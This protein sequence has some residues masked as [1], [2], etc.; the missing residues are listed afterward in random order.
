M[1]GGHHLCSLEFPPSVTSQPQPEPGRLSDP[2]SPDELVF[3]WRFDGR[4][5]QRLAGSIASQLATFGNLYTT[6]KVAEADYI[7]LPEEVCYGDSNE[8][9]EALMAEAKEGVKV[10]VLQAHKDAKIE[11]ATRKM[12]SPPP[13]YVTRKPFGPRSFA[14][15]IQ[16]AVK[17]PSPCP[18]DGSNRISN[19]D[20]L[21]ASIDVIKEELQAQHVSQ[22]Q[23]RETQE[24]NHTLDL[25]FP[26][27]ESDQVLRSTPP[28]A[29]TISPLWEPKPARTFSAL[30]VEDNAL[31]MRILTRVLSQCGVPFAMAV[32]G[33]EAVEQFEQQQSA[34]VLLDINMPRMDG[35]EACM[36]IR[37][38]QQHA[39]H[40]IAITALSDDFSRRKGLDECGM[41]EWL[42]KPLNVTQFRDKIKA[43]QATFQQT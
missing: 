34:L 11:L 24:S 41:D 20:D 39:T 19:D 36:R 37:K 3:F 22:P 15:L 18:S 23:A 29:R 17:E 30:C 42:S 1:A 27:Y 9:L 2:S 13:V 28:A 16:L 40:I 12:G 38:V 31:N 33:V 35:Y 14:R 7:L 4:G 43:M 5:L 26:T 8:A 25:V 21:G 6:T 10:G 32:D